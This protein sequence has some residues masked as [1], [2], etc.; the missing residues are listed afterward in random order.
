MVKFRKSED[1]I[2]EVHFKIVYWGP[3]KSGKTTILETLHELAESKEKSIKIDI[4]TEK[5]MIK[6]NMSGGSTLYYD[7]VVLQS[8]LQKKVFYEVYSVPGTSR[9]KPLRKKILK[10]TDGII[11]V[12]DSEKSN[13]KENVESLKELKEM[14]GHDLIVKIPLIIMLNKRDLTNTIRISEVEQLLIEE[15]L[16]YE[17]ENP[18]FIWNPEIYI[19]IGTFEKQENVYKAFSE[20]ARRM[21]FYM[22]Y[23]NGKAPKFRPPEKKM[24]RINF[25]IPSDLKNDWEV[26]AKEHLNMSL[27]Q[28]IRSA[29]REYQKNYEKYEESS[30][31]LN[32]E[33]IEFKIEKIVSDKMEKII[34]KY[35]LQ[36]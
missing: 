33:L 31:Q 36:S 30:L 28:M 6:I 8:L 11:F 1:G 23:G 18:L 21:G 16:M 29:V 7:K 5:E 34:K 25:L 27:S 12:F 4:F 17:P 20:C 15:D 26:F 2:Q 19:S 9:F 3:H 22:L 24:A 14:T 10:G 35:N 13:W 32:K